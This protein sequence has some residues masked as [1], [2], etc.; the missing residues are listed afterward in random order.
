MPL[1]PL[2]LPALRLRPELP[3]RRKLRLQPSGGSR[4]AAERL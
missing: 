1:R 4:S 2:P 3:L